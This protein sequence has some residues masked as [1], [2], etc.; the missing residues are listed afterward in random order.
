MGY[1]GYL[2]KVGNYIIPKSFISA[3]T[4]NVTRNGQ[5]LDSTRDENGELHRDALDHFVIK[6]EFETVPLLTDVQMESVLSQIR[7]QYTNVTEQKLNAKVYVPMLGT[8][9]EQE[10]YLPDIKFGI[11]YADEQKI[12]YLKTRFALIGY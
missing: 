7:S 2:V 9:V 12:Q 3:E 11:Y 10:M 1:E 6:V 5:D 8:Y 4:Y